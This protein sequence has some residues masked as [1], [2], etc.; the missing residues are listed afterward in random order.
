MTDDV[1]RT[2]DPRLP[3]SG[4]PP[5]DVPDGD[6]TDDPTVAWEEG[7]VYHPPVDP[8]IAGLEADGEPRIAAGFGASGDDDPAGP[9]THRTLEYTED[10]VSERVRE[11]LLADSLG[12][13]YVDDLDIQ[14]A[15][16]VVRIAGVVEDLD[17]QDHLLGVVESVVGVTEVRDALRLPDDLPGDEPSA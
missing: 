8:P 15:D 14:S 9:D 11:A 5:E 12:S 7:E 2:P 3:P 17:I 1:I 16:G 10:E 4:S 13:L 6:I